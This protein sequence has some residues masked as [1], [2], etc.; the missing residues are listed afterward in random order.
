V[1]GGGRPGREARAQT[2]SAA[3]DAVRQARDAEVRAFLT[4]AQESI[5]AVRRRF[6]AD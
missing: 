4:T 3:T 1:G 6:G 2:A 5:E